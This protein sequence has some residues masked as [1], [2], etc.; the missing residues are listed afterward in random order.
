MVTTSRTPKRTANKGR[1]KAKD[2]TISLTV[3]LDRPHKAMTAALDVGRPFFRLRRHRAGAGRERL[4]CRKG[5]SPPC[6]PHRGRR[7]V[8]LFHLRPLS[9]SMRRKRGGRSCPE[10]GRPSRRRPV[11]PRKTSPR[12]SHITTREM[13]IFEHLEVSMALGQKHFYN[14]GENLKH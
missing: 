3:V 7:M 14:L 4:R 8:A 9:R 1:S 2:S 6:P 11:R 10:E 12:I 5:R 13:T